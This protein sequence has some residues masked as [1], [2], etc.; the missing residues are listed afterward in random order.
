ML[1]G[2]GEG[3]DFSMVQ[4][5]ET[6]NPM[7]KTDKII[8]KSILYSLFKVLKK[9]NVTTILTSELPEDNKTLSADGVSEFIADGVVTLYYLGVGSSEFR[10]LQIRKMRYTTHNKEIVPYE[11]EIT[12]ICL[13][14]EKLI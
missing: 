10:S 3:S 13:K 9:F 5:A 4:I 6:V 1:S 11:I 7:P 8:T 14:H 2:I 12:G